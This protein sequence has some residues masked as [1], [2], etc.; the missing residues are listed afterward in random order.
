M[1]EDH[2]LLGSAKSPFLFSFPCFNQNT[3]KEV[4]AVA[5]KQRKMSWQLRA[6]HPS[7]GICNVASS[8]LYRFAGFCETLNQNGRI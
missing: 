2:L 3:G 8:V 7:R 5:M 4:R 1:T 6:L